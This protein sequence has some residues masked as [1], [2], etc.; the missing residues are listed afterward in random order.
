MAFQAAVDK[1]TTELKARGFGTLPGLARPLPALDT[2]LSYDRQRRRPM[3]GGG[4]AGLTIVWSRHNTTLE[5]PNAQPE[6]GSLRRHVELTTN[7]TQEITMNFKSLKR[8]RALSLVP[9]TVLWLAAA[10]AHGQ[11]ATGTA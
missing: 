1:V 4:G 11:T 10:P 7:S 2:T 3:T 5:N 8:F 6:R 9:L